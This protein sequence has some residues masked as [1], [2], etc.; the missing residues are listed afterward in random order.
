M[1]ENICRISS[2]ID[3]YGEL[4]RNGSNPVGPAEKP[5][6]LETF[7]ALADQCLTTTNLLE[8]N[9]QRFAHLEEYAVTKNKFTEFVFSC[10][11]NKHFDFDGLSTIMWSLET[12]SRTKQSADDGSSRTHTARLPV[13]T[14]YGLFDSSP[15]S[16]PRISDTFPWNQPKAHRGT[17]RSTKSHQ[18]ATG[19]SYS[20][21]DHISSSKTHQRICKAFSLQMVLWNSLRTIRVDFASSQLPLFSISKKT[22]AVFSPEIKKEMVLLIEMDFL[23]RRKTIQS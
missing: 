11:V 3:V 1:F 12:Q 22:S 9:E 2:F 15:R 20:K 21:A 5:F 13:S 7:T 10:Q 4:F 16:V 17:A 18:L 14:A 19:P 8:S 6:L 23:M